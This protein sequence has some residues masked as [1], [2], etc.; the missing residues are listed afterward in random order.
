MKTS[1][2]WEKIKTDVRFKIQ[3]YK[4]PYALDK[5]WVERFLSVQDNL[6]VGGWLDHKQVCSMKRN[7]KLS[8][9][10]GQNI[11]CLEGPSLSISSVIFQNLSTASSKRLS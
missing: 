3:D 4:E 7:R 6:V 1:E 11:P 2:M 8:I 10:V 5:V 9:H